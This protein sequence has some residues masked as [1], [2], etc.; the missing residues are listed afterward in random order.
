MSYKH[1]VHYCTFKKKGSA[2]YHPHTAPYQAKTTWK[3]LNNTIA[4][5]IFKNNRLSMFWT[6]IVMTILD[7]VFFMFIL[8]RRYRR[9]LWTIMERLGGEVL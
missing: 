2:C 7:A 8:A 3:P 4:V 9:Q 5:V 1:E 6:F